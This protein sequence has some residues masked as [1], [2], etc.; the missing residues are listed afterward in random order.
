VVVGKS[1]LQ[2]GQIVT[3]S[4]YNLPAGQPARQKF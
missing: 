1:G 3:A 4:A 2:D